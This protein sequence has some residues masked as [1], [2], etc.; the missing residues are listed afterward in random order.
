MLFN[1]CKTCTK[2]ES[3]EI[4]LYAPVKTKCYTKHLIG[5]TGRTSATVKYLTIIFDRKYSWPGYTDPVGGFPSNIIHDGSDEVF[6]AFPDAPG[7]KGKINGIEPSR[8]TKNCY[9]EY[10]N[11]FAATQALVQLNRCKKHFKLNKLYQLSAEKFFGGESIF[12]HP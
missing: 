12:Y 7:Q 9:G 6:S 11:R 3:G 4:L 2:K 10:K 5:F 8:I 1:L